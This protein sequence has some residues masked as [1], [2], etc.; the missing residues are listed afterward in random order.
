MK[1]SPR[2]AVLTAAWVMLMAELIL[3]Q[4]ASAL[5]IRMPDLAPYPVDDIGDPD[6]SSSGRMLQV[7]I[8]GYAMTAV[9]TPLGPSFV[10]YKARP[11]TASKRNRVLVQRG[12][13]KR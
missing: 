11:L 3:P 4:S 10:L 6:G 2:W 1:R 8:G 12:R 5:R 7:P 13:E 9:V